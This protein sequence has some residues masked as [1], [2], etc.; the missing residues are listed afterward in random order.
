MP[1]LFLL[2]FVSGIMARYLGTFHTTLQL[3]SIAAESMG[4][5]YAR[6]L[7]DNYQILHG[8]RKEQALP[9]RVL[10]SSNIVLL[11]VALF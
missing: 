3:V 11:L 4:L 2:I 10:F 9:L 5:A 7:L 8:N 6:L 1:P